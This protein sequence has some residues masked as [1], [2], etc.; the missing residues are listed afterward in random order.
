MAM[1]DENSETIGDDANP[2]SIKPKGTSNPQISSINETHT[3]NASTK[4]ITTPQYQFV[5]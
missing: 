2:Q 1:G 4:T 3:S 5:R